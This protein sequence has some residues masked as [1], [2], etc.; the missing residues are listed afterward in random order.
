ILQSLAEFLQQ[1]VTE[2]GAS[3]SDCRHTLPEVDY[4]TAVLAAALREAKRRGVKDAGD[5]SA[6]SYSRLLKR[7]RYDGSFAYTEW[8]YG[9]LRD[10]RSY[11]RPQAMTLFHLLYPAR[12]NGM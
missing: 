12:G 5:L 11:P 4:F 8:D 1:G 9:V 10:G 3:A 7:Q 6:R 2:T